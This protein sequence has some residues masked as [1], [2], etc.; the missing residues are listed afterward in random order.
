M[1][2]QNRNWYAAIEL[3]HSRRKYVETPV[4]PEKLERLAALIEELNDR[5]AAWRIA[6][7][8]SHT[9]A[10]F[11]GIRG[12]YGI[13]RGAPSYL[14]FIG[15]PGGSERMSSSATSGKRRCSRP[16]TLGSAPAGCREP[17]IPRRPQ[18]TSNLAL[19]TVSARRSR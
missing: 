11:S 3:R 8:R 16:R 18:G 6:L 19:G 2:E 13:I 9:G 17:S 15:A 7:V 4:E 14:A 5:S 10:M 12:G 1:N